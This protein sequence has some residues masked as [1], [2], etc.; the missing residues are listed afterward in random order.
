M[1]RTVRFMVA[2]LVVFIMVI[3]VFYAC[4]DMEAKG[5]HED[6]QNTA[7]AKNDDQIM[8][9]M[10]ETPGC[11]YLSWKGHGDLELFRCAAAGKKIKTAKVVRA[12]FSRILDSEYVRYKVCIDKLIP[13]EKYYYEIGSG[14][15]KNFLPKKSGSFY[16]PK[17]KGEDV[18]VYLGDPQT[19]ESIAD[20]RE[21][22]R[23]LTGMYEKNP[24]VEFA[25]V[26]GDLVNVPTEIEQWE[27]FFKN[28]SLLAKLPVMTV[29]GNH[30]GVSSN[31]TYKKLFHNIDNGPKGEACYYF[32]YGHCR[33]IMLDTSFLTKERQQEM[34]LEVWLC[35]DDEIKRWLKK[36]L[37]ENDKRWSI[38]V[39]HH[40]AYGLHDLFSVSVEV[41]KNWLPIFEDAGTDLVLC[42]HQHV[43]M[44]T[45]KIDGIT[46]VMGVAGSKRSNYYR[47][48]NGPMY[49]KAIYAAGSNYQVIKATA[50][51]L[52]I[53]SYNNTGNI[54]DAARIF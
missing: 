10:G 42:G 24:D 31:E 35:K 12:N 38:V 1:K 16:A 22:G 39:M 3:G 8:L 53:I 28:S 43:Y 7:V 30:E 5:R 37:E 27:G 51:Q 47:G 25:V 15:K 54:V 2:I 17:A 52:K 34:G 50:F 49:C 40:P 36:T 46:H 21:W 19:H 23:L 6:N 45:K 13:G 32:D 18:F 9:S 48:F 33:F 26:G 14:T 20:Y 4:A 11:V 41:R 44:R 29:P